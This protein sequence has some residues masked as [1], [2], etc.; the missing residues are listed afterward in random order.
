MLIVPLG[1]I[2]FAPSPDEVAN[3]HSSS[4]NPTSVLRKRSTASGPPTRLPIIVAIQ[5]LEKSFSPFSTRMSGN[6]VCTASG[7]S[8]AVFTEG[9]VT[10]CPVIRSDGGDERGGA[11]VLDSPTRSSAARIARKW[12][13]ELFTCAFQVS[14]VRA[15]R[16]AFAEASREAEKLKKNC[17]STTRLPSTSRIPLR[18][19]LSAIIIAFSEKKPG[20]PLPTT[21]NEPWRTP[22]AG[23]SLPSVYNAV[24]NLKSGPSREIAV[25][26]VATFVTDAGLKSRSALCSART[27]P[28]I[29]VTMNP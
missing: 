21:Y 29:V 22:V 28:F 6:E 18:F 20:S 4:L 15:A 16:K 9:S 14:G 8:L 12:V 26:D 13:Y 3:R 11:G 5:L 27:S 10:V 24:R 19:I 2:A 7:V 17:P 1:E 25:N 23:S